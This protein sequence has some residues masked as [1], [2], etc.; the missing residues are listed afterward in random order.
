MTPE[1]QAPLQKATR[2]LAAAKLLNQQN[3][4]EF[5]AARAY[6]TM[7]YV[8]EAFLE[9]EG[10]SFSK[11]SAVISAFGQRFANSGRL[12]VEFHRYLITAEQIRRQGDYD[13]TVI[14]TVAQAAEQISRAEQFLQLAEQEIG[15]F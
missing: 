8:V 10:L 6:Y 12:P 4:P 14:L 5:A 7:L 2:S 1:Q 13:A 3:L 9:G 15:Q 11:H